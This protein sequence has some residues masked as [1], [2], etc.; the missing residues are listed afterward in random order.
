[1]KKLMILLALGLML[2][3]CGNATQTTTE[4]GSSQQG[5]EQ[6]EATNEQSEGS[7][8]GDVTDSGETPETPVQEAG[9]TYTYEDMTITFPASWEGKY[10][11]KDGQDGF[12]IMQK[13]SYEKEEGWGFLFGFYRSDEMVDESTGATQLAYTKDYVYYIQEPTDVTFWYDDGD[14]AGEYTEMRKNKEEIIRSLAVDAEGVCYDAR[15][16]V[17][18]VSDTKGIPEYYLENFSEHTLWLARNEIYARHGRE[19]TNAYLANYFASCSWYTPT[20]VADAFDENVLSQTEKN[21]LDKITLQEEKLAK[22]KTYPQSCLFGQEYSYDLDGD[23]KAE[24]FELNYHEDT[25][26]SIYNVTMILDGDMVIELSSDAVY[27]FYPN[28]DEYYITDISPH[29]AGL[30]IAVMDYGM[31]DDLVTHFYTFDGELHYL[32]CVGGFPFKEYMN[33]DGFMWD[34]CVLGIIRT[35]LIHTCFSYANWYYDYQTKKLT[36]AED[37]IFEMVPTGAHELTKDIPVHISQDPESGTFTMKA[38]PIFFLETDAL[39]WIKIKGKDG[40]EGYLYITDGMI[41]GVEE[42]PQ[43]IISGLFFAG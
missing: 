23:G 4:S 7:Q 43:D 25:K 18:P 21:N 9:E 29:F 12:A 42:N 26:N 1:M 6:Q 8:T 32:G 13:S 22:A 36:I 5:R 2:A 20:V 33:R 28:T 10:V 19:F 41:D 30:E 16:Y 37:Q 34:G 17:L 3:G 40:M 35:D 31:S 15:E 24:T 39:E 38:Q 14:I 27:Y 11:I